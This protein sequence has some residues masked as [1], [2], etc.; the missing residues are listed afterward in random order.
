M[1]SFTRGSRDCVRSE[2]SRST[3]SALA[4][5]VFMAQPH[6]GVSGLDLIDQARKV[7]QPVVLRLDASLLGRE[8]AAL[9]RLLHVWATGCTSHCVALRFPILRL[10]PQAHRNER[11]CGTT[12]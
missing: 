4:S 5:V 9:A 3:C 12:N 8:I 7:R 2:Y 6:V 1:V 10:R 11:A